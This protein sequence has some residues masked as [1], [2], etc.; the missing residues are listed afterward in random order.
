MELLACL[1]I[2][3]IIFTAN[4]TQ[5]QEVLSSEERKKEVVYYVTA[6]GKDCPPDQEQY[7]QSLSYYTTLPRWTTGYS[8]ITL[9]FLPGEHITF[10]GGIY[11]LGVSNVTLKGMQP[12]SSQSQVH[13]PIIKCREVGIGAADTLVIDGLKFS[14]HTHSIFSDIANIVI[15]KV[16]SQFL[17]VVGG[18]SLDIYQSEFI[19]KQRLTNSSEN[20]TIL[21]L[22]RLTNKLTL[23]QTLISGTSG[24]C[25][26]MSTI[27]NCFHIVLS[28]VIISCKGGNGI[29]IN[30]AVSYDDT[31]CNTE[32]KNDLILSNVTISDSIQNSVSM[33]K[34]GKVSY[35]D[36]RVLNAHTFKLVSGSNPVTLTR[37]SV[38]NVST[39]FSITTDDARVTLTDVSVINGGELYLSYCSVCNFRNVL[40]SNS[41]G[42]LVVDNA[43][44][45]ILL[46]NCTLVGNW[47][48]GLSAKGQAK[49]T[50]SVHPSIIANNISPG[51]GG[52]MWVSQG[53]TIKFYTIVS[54]TNN[55]AKGVGGA[56][57]INVDEFK[58]KNPFCTIEH[59]N[60]NTSFQNNIG[61]L[62]GNDIYGGLYWDCCLRPNKDLT[63]LDVISS[64]Y[65]FI[66]QTNC[67]GSVVFS[68][69]PQKFLSSHI[70]S[71]PIGVCVCTSDNT[72]DCSIRTIN[73]EI[74]PSQ[75]ID[76]SLA[77][78]GVC[79]GISPGELVTHNRDKDIEIFLQDINQETSG[80]HCKRFAYKLKPNHDNKAGAF[81]LDHKGYPGEKDLTNSSLT[82]SV[83][84]L[85]CPLGLKFFSK[86]CQC[87]EAIKRVNGT[88]CSIDWMPYPI[89]RSGN[90]WLSYNEEYNCT[91]A[92][93]NCPFDYCN[94]SAVYLNLN[95]SNLQCTN[96]RSGI[97][98]GGCQPGLSLTLG[99][100]NCES[101]NDV[102]L[103]LVAAFITAGIALVVFLL[104]CNMTV[105]VGSING[106]LFYANLIKLNEATLFPNGVSIPVLSQFI[107][108]LNLDLGI[109]TCF[110]NGLDG[111]WKTW[112][113][114]VFPV[115]IWLLIGI[116]I[117]GSYYSGRLSRL[118]G[119]NAVP[120]LATLILMSYNKLIRNITN[121]LMFARIECQPNKW[122]NVW[123]VD[124]N[125]GYLSSKHSPLFLIALLFLLT[126]LVYTGLVFSIQWL[127][128]Y[129][130]KCCRKSS[131]DPVVKLKPFLDAYTGPY[132][133]KYRYWTG[134]LL[135]VRLLLTTV[136][137]YTTGTVP[138]VNNYIIAF[139]SAGLVFLSRGVYRETSLNILEYFYLFNLGTL[140]L[141]NGLS[142][143]MRLS[144]LTATTITA[145]SVGL[146][147]LAFITT[148]LVHVVKKRCCRSCCIKNRERPSLPST[149][150][151][152]SDEEETYSPAEFI[153]SRR[154]PLIFD[155]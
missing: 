61:H 14:Y 29:M 26:T 134:L 112:L 86:K 107:A 16:S 117:I 116:I 139:I 99:S 28:D 136:F 113:Q 27:S 45:S 115:Y 111:Y 66:N 49:L 15:R 119:N 140:S 100:N 133:D 74:Y 85:P 8:N 79:G 32:E 77:T 3:V 80:K 146:S 23:H 24:N 103:L 91:V 35:T 84:F 92:H 152:K 108:W 75:S 114:F 51:N 67:N 18:S 20:Y 106:L 87:N 145:V 88:H 120:V 110:F 59:E 125:I 44:S 60:A 90:N 56:V 31:N 33:M 131:R 151:T 41:S 76:L 132:K 130:G 46:I 68:N 64:E 10:K 105:S 82:I 137:S 155:F 143:H 21:E 126:G 102:Y 19:V 4:V 70:T 121:A 96:G 62:G 135:I 81:S 72:T 57:Y 95:E 129:S 101:C 127:Q 109:Q 36:I 25:L 144:N 7:C 17:T 83:K 43:K 12:N 138:Q 104:V 54:F 9:I 38:A 53:I 123:S 30:N 6:T 34:N 69:F 40:V 154:E 148:V 13:A 142:D 48:T 122:W 22:I 71:N 98:C 1:S 73:K 65:S 47:N 42:G 118:C 52:G 97:L 39:G 147:F 93:E 5:C 2:I 58:D 141:L 153:I 37:V 128:R 63:C 50:F 78:V 149:S 89:R 55:T 94:T 124:G 150:N 11:I